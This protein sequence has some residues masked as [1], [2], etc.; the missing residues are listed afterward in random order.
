MESRKRYI[1]MYI[2]DAMQIVCKRE[3]EEGAVSDER[4]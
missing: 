1:Q 2:S 4:K 3:N